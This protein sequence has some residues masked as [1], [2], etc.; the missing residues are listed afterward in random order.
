MSELC[1]CVHEQLAQLPLISYPFD[2]QE[3]PQN[4]IYFFYEKGEVWGHG[5]DRPR[6]VRIGGHTGQGNLRSCIDQTYV[7]DERRLDFSQ[8]QARPAD[9]GSSRKN[10]GRAL[11]N[12]DGDDYLEIWDV[13]LIP[14][15]TRDCFRHL[16]D[17]E[18]EK[19]L[20]E[21]ISR[22]VR[23]RFSFR[24]IAVEAQTERRELEKRLVGTV[25]GCDL[26]L[27][28][29]SWL[30]RSSPKHKI[31]QGKLWQVQNLGAHPIDPADQAAIT[32]AIETTRG[33][34]GG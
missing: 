18:K 19:R 2:L 23:D 17:L 22:I 21:A 1:K 4:G 3:L 30:G 7:L 14:R 12:K 33:W 5:G 6:V 32:V 15:H 16:R 11:L 31:R 28:S 29:H 8:K 10:I 25:A 27:P 34:R 26:C 20:E 13:D 9:W 24:V